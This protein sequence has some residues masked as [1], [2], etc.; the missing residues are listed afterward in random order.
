VLDA[1]IVGAGPAGIGTALALDAVEGLVYGIVER[2]EIG[3]TF[4]RWPDQQHFLTPSFTGNGF[5]A[6]DLNSVH[7]DTSPAFSLGLDYPGGAGYARYLRGVA[8]H[9]STPILKNTDVTSIALN[10]GVFTVET[11]NGPVESRTVIWAGGEF[12][13]PAVPRIAGIGNGDHSSSPAAWQKREG[14]LV[15][16][17]GYESGIDLACHHVMQGTRVTVIDEAHPWHA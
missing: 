10:H 5:G 9:F 4:L 8:T 13:S 12:Q 7:P 6:T 1:L 15:V 14:A 11:T 3:E 2:G 17:G 16:V